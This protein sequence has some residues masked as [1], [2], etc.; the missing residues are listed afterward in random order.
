VYAVSPATHVFAIALSIVLALAGISSPR[1]RAAGATSGAVLGVT[2]LV[3]VA[4]CVALTLFG[5]AAYPAAA[6]D[7]GGTAVYSLVLAVALGAYVGVGLR[8]WPAT[9]RGSDTSPAGGPVLVGLLLGAGWA[10][11][12]VVSDHAGA[13]ALAIGVGVDGLIV[14]GGF[15]ARLARGGITERA[16]VAVGLRTGLVAALAYFVAGMSATYITASWPV[17]DHEVLEA[18][19]ASGLPDLATYMVSE[20]L[21]GSIVAL[22]F[23][24]AL[25]LGAT[26]AGGAFVRSRPGSRPGTASVKAVGD[27]GR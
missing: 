25:V 19:R 12:S 17:R 13:V 2:L 16:L 27:V 6:A 9:D 26:W 14:A 18:F 21:G 4:A 1:R 3:G 7:D 23:V 15:G 10:V 20:T 11:V 24:P 5:V 22:V 8:S